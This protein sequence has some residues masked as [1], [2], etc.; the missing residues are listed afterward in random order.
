MATITLEVPDELSEQLQQLGDRLPQ[1]LMQTLQQ[2]PLPANAYRYIL[3]FL[4]GQPTPAEIANFRPT[5]EMQTRLR[6]LVAKAK[7]DQL[8]AAESQELL[9][10]E[11]IEHLVVMLK[12]C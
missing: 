6:E 10:Y 3:N 4:A 1:L 11:H 2:P 9:E 12:Q 5:T 7:D 8:S